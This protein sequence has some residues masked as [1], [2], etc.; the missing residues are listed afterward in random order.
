VTQ[1]QRFYWPEVTAVD[2]AGCGLRVRFERRGD[3]YGQLID[4]AEGGAWAACLESIEG[5]GDDPW[6]PSPPLQQ[7]SIEELSPGRLVALMVGM[8]GKSHWSVS[9]ECAPTCTSLIFDVACRL[10][11]QPRLLA[12]SYR[13]LQASSLRTC[14]PSRLLV[15]DGA[16]EVVVQPVAGSAPAFLEATSAG[17]AVR[18]G[19]KG[20]CQQTT[21]RWRYRVS[22]LPRSLRQAPAAG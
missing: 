17:F 10:A 8:A 4:V 3:R 2:A 13:C 16:A 12:S 11:R 1:Q 7:L 5:D 15:A 20:L 14:D 21:I 22:P 6:P 18:V 9:V 19:P